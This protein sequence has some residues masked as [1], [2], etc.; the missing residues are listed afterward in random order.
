MAKAVLLSES[1]LMA[2]SRKVNREKVQA[3]LDVVCPK[4]GKVITPAEVRR[5]D[6]QNIVCPA[7]GEQFAPT[8]K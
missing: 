8:R 5:V 4:C 6:F 1:S 2:R 3:S 7:C